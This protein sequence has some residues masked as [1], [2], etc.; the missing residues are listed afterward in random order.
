MSVS[1]KL[2]V[3]LAAGTAAAVMVSSFLPFGSGRCLFFPTFILSACSRE[4]EESSGEDVS[5]SFAIFDLFRF[6]FG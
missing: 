6:L 3:S 2:K 4:A 5:Y 1:R